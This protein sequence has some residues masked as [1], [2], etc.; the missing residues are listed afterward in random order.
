MKHECVLPS[1]PAHLE[2][3]PCSKILLPERERGALPGVG[4]R[5]WGR[6]TGQPAGERRLQENI[7]RFVL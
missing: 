2:E 7:V 3:Y 5:V 4:H 6:L 1:P